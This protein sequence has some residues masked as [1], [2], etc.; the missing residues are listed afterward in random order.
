MDKIRKII[1]DI[2]RE[3]ESE[4]FQTDFGDKDKARRGLIA[5]SKGLVPSEDIKRLKGYLGE[6]YR[7]EDGHYSEDGE[8]EIEYVFE[9]VKYDIIMAITGEYYYK[10]GWGGD[11]M[12]PPD[13]DTYED[14]DIILNDEDFILGDEERNEYEFKLNELG[15]TFKKDMENFLVDYYDASD[16][17]L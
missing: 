6:A 8:V 7:D 15:S 17:S 3:N 9:G 4:D 13:E 11:Y 2:L 12:Q 5:L 14:E 10:Q 1:R 16:S